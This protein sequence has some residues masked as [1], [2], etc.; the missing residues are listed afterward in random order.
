[1]QVMRGRGA[2]G[3]AASGMEVNRDGEHNGVGLE[4]SSTE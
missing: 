2:P 4:G 3:A 1:M